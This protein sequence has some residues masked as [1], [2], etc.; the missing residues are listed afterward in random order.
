MN[1]LC[2]FPIPTIQLNRS[3]QKYDPTKSFPKKAFSKL[4]NNAM[5]SGPWIRSDGDFS[6]CSE[7]VLQSLL[8]DSGDMKNRLN[9]SNN[10]NFFFDPRLKKSLL[11]VDSF[12]CEMYN[13]YTL[14][15]A[16]CNSNDDSVVDDDSSNTSLQGIVNAWTIFCRGQDTDGLIIPDFHN[17]PCSTSHDEVPVV[18]NRIETNAARLGQYFASDENAKDVSV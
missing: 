17:I 13:I 10:D 18:P 8:S 4:C 7:L 3:L 16:R 1:A 11:V 9:D 12:L 6:E 15:V 5:E 14:G 2:T